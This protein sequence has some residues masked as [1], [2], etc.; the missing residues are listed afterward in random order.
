MELGERIAERG[1]GLTKAERRVAEVVLARPQLV[2]FGTVAEL[3]KASGV[4]AATVVRMASKLGLDGFTELQ[5]EVRR[6][7]AGL[8]R[9]AAERIRDPADHDP[10]QHH[11]ELELENVR[12]TLSGLGADVLAASVEHLA[13]LDGEVLV[14]SGDASLGIAAHLVA[15]LDA[16]RPGVSL[17]DGNEVAVRRRLALI[18]PPSSVVLIDIRRYDRWVVEAARDA[19]AHGAWILSLT[20]SVLS[21]LASLS[22]A[23]VVLHAGGGGPFDS[24]VGTVAV[25]NLLVAATAHR[26]RAVATDRLDR[27]EHAWRDSGALVDR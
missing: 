3:A 12:S 4:G 10:I 2:A 19:R 18:E 8:L 20:D 26:L 17:L 27:A 16:L 6:E 9:P 21:P 11:L 14:V 1:A 15:E 7:L 24:H 22:D 25:G 13:D 5:S 23:V